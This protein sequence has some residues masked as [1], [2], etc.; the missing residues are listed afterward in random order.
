MLV[1]LMGSKPECA[2]VKSIPVDLHTGHG[3]LGQIFISIC[4]SGAK[5]RVAS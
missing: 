2:V 5:L 4:I 3:F 1:V